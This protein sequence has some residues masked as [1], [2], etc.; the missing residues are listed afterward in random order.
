V[1][2]TGTATNPVITL[3]RATGAADGYLSSTDFTAF[4][5]K[6]SDFSS[7]TSAD[8]VGA[9][10][11]TPL[12]PIADSVT[13]AMISS[14]DWTKVQNRP[15][16]LAGYG[17]GDALGTSTALSGD[18]TGTYNAT[19][20]T[21]IR[22]VLVDATAST[23]ASG[24]VL[25]FDGT[26]YIAVPMPTGAVASVAGRT[27][28]VTLTSADITGLGTAA[29]LNVGTTAG[30]VAAG[31]DA[32]FTDNR[33]PSGTASGDL[34]GTYPN[35][36][37]TKIRGVL[38]DAT[39]ST[40]A[41][42]DV[43]RFDGAKYIAVP[44][45][46]GAVASVA[47][48][49]GVV[50]LTSADIT[51]L[52]TAAMLN[53]GTTANRVVQ[54]DSSGKL[55][56]I[57]GSQLTNLPAGSD[58]TK[59]PLAGGIMTG[60]IITANGTAAAPAIGVG[61]TTSGIYSGGTNI[62]N[63]STAGTE[64]MRLNATG[65]LA[66]QGLAAQQIIVDTA[67]AS[68]AGAALTIQAGGGNGSNRAGGI[69]NLSAG[70]STG[71]T[72]SSIEFKTAAPGTSGSSTRAPATKMVVTGNGN[73]GVGVTNPTDTLQV[74][75]A[76]RGKSVANAGTTIDWSNGNTQSS[77]AGCTG[78]QYTFQ[79]MQDGGVYTLVITG[80]FS[81]NCT[82]GQTVPDV[83]SGTPGSG[84]FYFLPANSIPSGNNSVYSMMRVGNAVYIQWNSGFAN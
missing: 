84:A 83:L 82:F 62:L 16:S 44:M 7:L 2:N 79:N 78:T 39:A 37:V 17:I 30:T 75:G 81:A 10:T 3:N 55:P 59:L 69:L 20:V 21:K 9:L 68:T 4:A 38:V 76:I 14:V 48:R 5:A 34:S 11:Y 74:N 36:S 18:V 24:D 41:S 27:G 35:P 60:A 52:G 40:P 6:L 66:F 49:T 19:S 45:P 72:G 25:R 65:D 29:L 15:N 43:L 51:G 50:T 80:T 56:A 28:V 12:N 22:G 77:T 47:G 54:I 42:G 64:R 23:P 70:V 33:T 1:T 71:N 26:K 13:N 57:D 8:V 32:R 31:D 46:T 73:V 53:V 58:A 63:F 67:P 61:Q